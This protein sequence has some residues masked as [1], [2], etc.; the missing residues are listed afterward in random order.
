MWGSGNMIPRSMSRIRPSTSTQAQWRRISP[1]PP[2]NT[3]RTGL[4]TPSEGSSRSA[5]PGWWP[6]GEEQLSR[7][8]GRGAGRDDDAVAPPDPAPV[9]TLTG[10]PADRAADH[11]E[12]R[13]GPPQEAEQRGRH[14]QAAVLPPGDDDAGGDGDLDHDAEE[15]DSLGHAT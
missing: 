7:R 3:T 14:Q 13:Q 2:R 6:V 1:R 11:R 4:V 12:R 15:Q 5:P 10:D 8:P 9:H